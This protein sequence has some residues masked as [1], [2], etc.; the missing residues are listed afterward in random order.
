M[1]TDKFLQMKQNSVEFAAPKVI[2]SP[3]RGFLMTLLLLG[4]L[5]VA[6]AGD[7]LSGNIVKVLPLF[8]NLKGQDSI[9]PSL[10]DRDAYQVYLRVHT[11]E[12]SAIRY[13]ILWSTSK[14]DDTKLTLRLE[15][16]GAGEGGIPRQ[17]TLE[18]TVTPHYFRHWTS[19]PLAGDDYKNLGEGGRLARHALVWL[20]NVKRTKIIPLVNARIPSLVLFILICAW[21]LYAADSDRERRGDQSSAACYT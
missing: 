7:A 12:I 10:Y 2:V 6:D 5:V 15:L 9:S 14:T 21:P 13:D 19:L 17:T 20:A 11:N 18:Q 3:M 4:S 16:R 1:P 8:L